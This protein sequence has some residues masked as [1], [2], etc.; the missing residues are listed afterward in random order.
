MPFAEKN[1]AAGW[2]YE[3]ERCLELLYGHLEILVARDASACLEDLPCK[4]PVYRGQGA[5]ALV[6][7]R[8]HQVHV[9]RLV[10]GVAD[11]DDRYPDI[12]RFPEG[13]LVGC[14]VGDEEHLGLGEG[15]QDR[16]RERSGHEPT[17]ADGRAEGLGEHLR[18]LL[19]V[20]SCR[21][22]Q[23]PLWLHSREELCGH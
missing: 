21:D 2:P 22:D 4:E 11:P 5:S 6:V 19:A 7:R 15:G 16:V 18:R 10:V 20:L 17:R 14:R 23:Y 13:L 8:Y 9:L 1:G 12:Q 3:S